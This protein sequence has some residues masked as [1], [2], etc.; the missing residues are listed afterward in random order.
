MRTPPALVAAALLVAACGGQPDWEP[1]SRPEDAPPADGSTPAWT[2]LVLTLEDPA[3]VGDT[4]LAAQVA[5]VLRS[6]SER[7]GLGAEVALEEGGRFAIVFDEAL[8]AE[9]GAAAELLG[10]ARG[11]LVLALEAVEG[12]EV[13]R[14]V[15]RSRGGEIVSLG[16]RAPR[17]DAERF[18]DEDLAD[19]FLTRDM[20]GFPALG[21]ELT[22]ER[23]TDFADF[24]GGN[25]GRNL[26]VALDDRALSVAT[27]LDRL[28]GRGIVT[29]GFSEPEARALLGILAAEPLPAPLRVVERR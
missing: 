24:T 5:G 16:L 26:V 6:R 17:S 7:A 12:E 2:T 1:L 15:T 10:T 11:E 29:G 19:V 3:A 13:A 28:P 8:D 25:E 23:K 18:G 4:R 20:S 14:E 21:F 9:E 22:A 27:I